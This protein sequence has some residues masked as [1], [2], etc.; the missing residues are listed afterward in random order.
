MSLPRNNHPEQN[1]RNERMD[2]LDR[3]Y[4]IF[5]DVQVAYL[6]GDREL[7]R[8]TLALVSFD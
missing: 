6:T 5:P 7:G 2:L 1:S 8:Q 4:S 3:F